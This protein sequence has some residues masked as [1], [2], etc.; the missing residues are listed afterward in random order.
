MMP[1]RQ[2]AAYPLIAAVLT[3]IAACASQPPKQ[4][5]VLN[6]VP[7]GGSQPLPPQTVQHFQFKPRPADSVD[8]VLNEYARLD[9][10]LAAA[11]AG[12]DFAVEQ[13][14]AGAGRSALAESVRNEWLKSLGVRGFAD[15]FKQQYA[16]LEPEGRS[17]E[18]RC[19]AHGFGLEN[20]AAFVDAL[21]WET[22]RLPAGCNMLLQQ[23][24]LAGALDTDKAWRRVRGLIAENQISDAPGIGSGVGQS[25][26]RRRGAGGTGKPVDW[27]YWCGGAKKRRCG[28]AFVGVVGQFEP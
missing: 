8:K 19:Y 6:P 16:L 24:A 21:L 28:G 7:A 26:R 5:N 3:L 18:N 10:L 2:K 25:F 1:F 9:G 20:D 15:K 13:F 22:G 23:R 11:K 12:D 14:L 4:P 17:R 27:H